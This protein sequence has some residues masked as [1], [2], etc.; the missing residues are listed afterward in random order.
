MITKISPWI[1]FIHGDI[2]II[3][4]F[5]NFKSILSKN[6]NILFSDKLN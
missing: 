1:N 3:K 4:I 5:L 2:F 6:K